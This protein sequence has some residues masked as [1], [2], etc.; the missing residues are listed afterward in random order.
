MSLKV[1]YRHVVTVLELSGRIGSGESETLL[2]DAVQQALRDG[3]LN[4]LLDLQHVAYMDSTGLGELANAVKAAR[5]RHCEVKLLHVPPRVQDLMAITHLAAT[6]DIFT[7]E[8]VA[9]TTFR[10]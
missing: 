1:K 2:R 7:D 5:G 9:A 4:L 10:S 3:A 8:S 6:F